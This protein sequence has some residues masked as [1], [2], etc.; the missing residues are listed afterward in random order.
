MFLRSV[1][2]SDRPLG[3]TNRRRCPTDVAASSMNGRFQADGSKIV[4]HFSV[5]Q[6]DL[7]RLMSV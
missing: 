1:S 6:T 4:R 5:G 7:A 2:G 3:L